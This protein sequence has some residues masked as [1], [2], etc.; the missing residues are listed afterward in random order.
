MRF[1]IPKSIAS[2]AK[3]FGIYGWKKSFMPL[4]KTNNRKRPSGIYRF[5]ARKIPVFPVFI[6]SNMVWRNDKNI[7]THET[8]CHYYWNC[9]HGPALD[10]S[11]RKYL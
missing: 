11:A 1:P 2:C 4:L 9:S 10:V 8:N 6:P 7:R 3:I 5:N